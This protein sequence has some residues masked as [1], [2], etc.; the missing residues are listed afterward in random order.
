MAPK[1]QRKTSSTVNT[2]ESDVEPATTVTSEPVD[3]PVPPEVDQ[4][5]VTKKKAVKK[6]VVKAET[7]VVQT[8]TSPE[9]DVPK[10]RNMSVVSTDFVTS[11]YKS[12]PEDLQ[13][14]LKTKDVKELTE[15]FVRV[16]VDK[17]KDGQVVSFTNH[18]TFK[19]QVRS[20]RV[21]KN[22]KTGDPIN[23]PPH[24]VFTMQVKPALKKTFD[25]VSV[26]TVS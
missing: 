25:D 4:P 22:L 1:K 15:T 24:Y 10:K 8:D 2:V 14:V 9:D 13:K 23:K 18:M 26:S 12:L 21:Y 20:A 3:V 11:V 7:T 19:R 16:L 17:V 5:V 6:H